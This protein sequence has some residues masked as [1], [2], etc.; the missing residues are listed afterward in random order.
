MHEY[1]IAAAVQK[2]VKMRIGLHIYTSTYWLQQNLHDV[3]SHT[4]HV[5]NLISLHK[6]PF[7]TA[8]QGDSLLSS[9]YGAATLP[10]AV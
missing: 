5:N 1:N 6:S 2:C 9:A 7:G 10:V 3:V 8:A 4:A